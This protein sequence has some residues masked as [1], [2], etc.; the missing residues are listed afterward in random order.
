MTYP[1]GDQDRIFPGV[2]DGAPRMGP[3]MSSPDPVDVGDVVP[4]RGHIPLSLGKRVANRR[5]FE[6]PRGASTRAAVYLRYAA[7]F[8]GIMIASAV[9]SGCFANVPGATSGGMW[10]L[11]SVSF[12][13]ATA[14]VGSFAFANR[15]PEITQQVRSY[16]F[17]YTV[18]P[19]TGMAI[20]MWAA[21]HIPTGP[22]GSDVFVNSLNSALPWL[23]F[24]PIILPTVI[25]LKT[26]AGMRVL[27]RE[28]GDDQ[29]LMR[30]YTRID[31]RQR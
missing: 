18:L 9:T 28:Q 7:Y 22:T 24:L 10:M 19:G 17:G 16:V 5:T 26:V 3:R 23:Y 21:R 11:L 6:G 31:G 27:N 29:E 14:A 4:P 30:T 13:L 25:F 20:F 12:Q 15:R 8:L 1:G 2:S